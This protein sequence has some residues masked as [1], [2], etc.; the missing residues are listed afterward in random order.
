MP[1]DFPSRKLDKFVLRLPDGLRDKIGGAARA[2][3]RAMNAEIVS[4]LETSFLAGERP[5]PG[6]AQSPVEA[7]ISAL[8]D[9]LLQLRSEVAEVKDLVEQIGVPDF[10]KVVNPGNG[11]D[12]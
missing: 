5:I 7:S 4:R 6:V 10:T 2:N 3:K 11:D 12:V 9:Q 8:G 1:S